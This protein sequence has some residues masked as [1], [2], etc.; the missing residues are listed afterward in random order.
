MTNVNVHTSSGAT[1]GKGRAV[2]QI[3]VSRTLTR[4]CW[5]AQLCLALTLTLTADA[6]PLGPSALCSLRPAP[7]PGPHTRS[8]CSAPTT[9]TTRRSPPPF[10]TFP[11]ALFRFNPTFLPTTNTQERYSTWPPQRS[12]SVG[13]IHTRPHLLPLSLLPTLSLSLSFECLALR[14]SNDAS[15]CHYF[16]VFVLSRLSLSLSL[17]LRLVIPILIHSRQPLVEHHR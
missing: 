5:M 6:R 12:T 3:S 15:S 9:H 11:L 7:R 8:R 16:Y 2:L 13:L 1:T 14:V 17:S 10:H 4:G